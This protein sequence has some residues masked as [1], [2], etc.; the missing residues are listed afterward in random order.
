LGGLDLLIYLDLSNNQLKGPFPKW[1]HRLCHLRL[2]NLGQNDIYG[3]IPLGIGERQNNG[4]TPLT[5]IRNFIRLFGA[6]DASSPYRDRYVTLR[7]NFIK[8]LKKPYRSIIN[9]TDLL[10]IDRKFSFSSPI[11]LQETI[12]EYIK[13]EEYH[14]LTKIFEN[15]RM[16]PLRAIELLPKLMADT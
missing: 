16:D 4:C 6:T 2:L 3:E 5:N 11:N 13:A 7:Q 9:S 8:F 14:V 15:M 1:A 12:D 10:W